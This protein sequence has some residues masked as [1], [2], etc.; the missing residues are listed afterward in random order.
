VTCSEL[1]DLVPPH[2]I[3][4]ALWAWRAEG[5]HLAATA[6]AVDLVECA[7]RGEAFKPRLLRSSVGVQLEL[8]AADVS[9]AVMSSDLGFYC[10][11]VCIVW[12]C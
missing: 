5:D 9:P 12:Q 8:W 11:L 2:A 3:D 1:G 6:C 7:L 4:A 10:S